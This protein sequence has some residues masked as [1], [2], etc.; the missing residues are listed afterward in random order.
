MR[1]WQ[2]IPLRSILIVPVLLQV[3][4]SVILVAYFA[5]NNGK[6]ALEKVSADLLIKVGNEVEEY[7]DF[8]LKTP[9]QVN[10][11]NQK[12]IASKLIN[13]NQIGQ[14]FI[15]QQQTY[16]FLDISY[17]NQKQELIGVGYVDNQV[18]LRKIQAPNFNSVY[19]SLEQPNNPINLNLS[20]PQLKDNNQSLNLQ[21]K[22][23]FQWQFL[24]ISHN[25]N[26]E[27]ILSNSASLYEP[28][29]K[30]LGTL[31]IQ[32]STK[33]INN[34]LQSRS[35]SQ[36]GQ[37]LIVEK[38]GLLIANSQTQSIINKQGERNSIQTIDNALAKS[39]LETINHNYGALEQISKDV[40]L[41]NDSQLMKIIPYQD[42]HGL[43]WFII[44][45]VPR[46]VFFSEIDANKQN[47]LI[48]CLITSLVATAMGIVSTRYISQPILKICQRANQLAQGENIELLSENSAIQELNLL[49]HAFN[50]MSENLTETFIQVENS[51]KESENRYH[52][53]MEELSDF[54]M[55]SQ[56]DTTI[57]FVGEDLC[58]VLG[59]AEEEIIGRKWVE[60]VAEEENNRLSVSVKISE[61]TPER[62]SLTTKNCLQNK[63]QKVVWIE[64]VHRGIFNQEGKLIAIES[65]GENISELKEVETALHNREAKYRAIYEQVAVGI[66]YFNHEQKF[67][68]VN[69]KFC[70]ML[71]YTKQELKQKTINDI[72]H[73][74]DKQQNSPL[75][76]QL[77]NEEINYFIL[78]QR[79]LTK[80][81]KLVWFKI[82]ASLH[83]PEEEEAQIIAIVEDITQEKTI[84]HELYQANQYMEAIFSA[85]PDILFYVKADG[86]IED[87]KANNFSDLYISTDLFSAKKIQD[88][89][90]SEI[91]EK[92][93]QAIHETINSQKT[94]NLEFSLS[95]LEQEKFYDARFASISA[96]FAIIV[97][98]DITEI[99]EAE[100][101]RRQSELEY[102]QILDAITD[103]VFV[104]NTN[105]Q[106]LWANKAFRDYYGMN[107]EQIKMLTNSSSL[108]PSSTRNYLE[109]DRQVFTT[110]KSITI[111]EEPVTRHD[112]EIRLFSTIKSPIWV[113]NEEITKLVGVARDITKQKQ[114]ENDLARAKEIAEAATRAKS[115]FL[116]NMSHE[117]R[118]P[119]NGVIGMIQLLS[120]TPLNEEQSDLLETMTNSAN[121]LL[122]IINDLL[123][124]SKIE[125]G[126]LELEKRAFFIADI[127]GSVFNLLSKQASD[128]KVN[129][130]YKLDEPLRCQFIGD[131]VRL[132][133]VFL[134]LVSNA[135][136]FTHE[137]DVVIS[138]VEQ[139]KIADNVS[140][141]L[142]SIQDTGIGISEEVLEKLFKPF[143]QGDTSVS[144]KFGGTGLGLVICKNLIDLMGGQIWVESKGNLSGNPPADW[145]KKTSPQTEGSTF[146]FTVK[147]QT[148]LEKV[149]S[150]SS[151]QLNLPASNALEEIDQFSS[152]K[153]L[154]VEDNLINQKVAL[155]SLKKLGYQADVANNG[156]EALAKLKEKSYQLILMDIQM[157]EMDG[158]TATQMIRRE[159]P[160]HP[161]IIGLTANAF[162][163]DREKC[164]S[165]GMN[166]YMTKPISLV[167]MGNMLEQYL[168]TSEEE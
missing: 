46:S 69:N 157:P 38:S 60:T 15:Q 68:D 85:F 71:G 36:S 13:V 166:D 132:Q 73:I 116:A 72:T 63:E 147:L 124:F 92:V 18:L 111:A 34:F 97:I 62:A 101:N 50:E 59:Y 12:L 7:L 105:S 150:S 27:L 61:L 118:T 168:S 139:Q 152:V 42:D 37:V 151:L 17:L 80:D 96:E 140:E 99:K 90:P 8:Y 130:T 66:V 159:N 79:F 138:I 33:Q 81:S 52:N 65:L 128:Q 22:K 25:N 106:I 70:Q 78:Q 134:N 77:L 146:F 10:Q 9:L 23:D 51:L 32:I 154:L 163:E 98:R 144:R 100:A 84:T 121:A 40:Y 131:K 115:R 135:V 47:T 114:V 137:G 86:T 103:M 56:P 55:R 113:E 93:Y 31:N 112:G 89:L 75:W 6:K 53:V 67:L 35:F 29:Q 4:V 102:Q 1:F 133:Q 129:L 141:L 28:S 149:N 162:A 108:N 165:I 41:T 142:I 155:L 125:A 2:N 74:Q 19:Y 122:T 39:T 143:S 126:M 54:T 82:T 88:I 76:Q 14:Y 91:G 167:K 49:A 83:Q 158:L 43:D 11:L 57:T 24:T 123:D 58:D 160:N 95:M 64:W 94:I 107:L 104:K 148:S 30:F 20:S 127:L 156:L 110:Q 117:I 21:V 44:I 5:H 164:L 120:M 136:K 87:Y 3:I 161:I 45:T 109:D 48:F 26:Y 153:I 119:M 145:V 16:D